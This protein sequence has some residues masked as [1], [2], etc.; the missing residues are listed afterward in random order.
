MSYQNCLRSLAN[1]VGRELSDKEIAAVYER[2]HKAALD[3]KSGRAEVGDIQ[4]GKKLANMGLAN[5]ALIQ[6][7]AERAARDLAFEAAANAK[8]AYLQVVRTGALLD[9]YKRLRG[10][11]LSP[12]KAV[13][14]LIFRNYGGVNVESLEQR[15][16]GVRDQLERRMI[17]SW[18]AMGDRFFGL[19]RDPEK[20]IDII[21]ELRGEDSGNA[22]AKA[23]ASKFHEVAEEARQWANQVGFHIG[24][25]NDWA[26]PQHHSQTKAANASAIVHGKASNDPEV[27]KKAWV[28]R[29]MERIDR[30][31]YV[32]DLGVQWSEADIRKSLEA[33]WESVST[34]G[35]S[36]IEPGKFV[37][38]SRINRHSQHRFI[39]YKDAQAVLDDWRE[40]GERGL[41]EIL[42]NHIQSMARDIAIAEF[43]GPRDRA[44]FNTLRDTAM[45]EAVELDRK[46]E[47]G[48]RGDFQSLEHKYDY[49][50][51]GPK[52]QS[53]RPGFSNFMDSIAHLNTAAK[54]GGFM[55]SSLFGDRPIYQAVAHL[56]NLPVVR[57][58]M[59][60]AKLFAS[61]RDRAALQR[62]G[63]MLD[64]VQVGLTRFWDDFG[65]SS[66]ASAA[67]SKVA[68]AVMRVTGMAAINDIPKA[69][70][71]AGL[72][73]AI[74]RELHKPFGK[75]AESDVRLLRNYGITE[76]DWKTW[77]LAPRD[78]NG[79]TP[80][81]IERITDDSLRQAGII[82]Q[83]A[84]AREAA[85][86][87]RNAIVKL[88]GAINTEADF[89][90]VTP[91]WRER[92]QFYS[93]AQRGSV[94]GEI[95]RAVLQFKSFPWAQLLRIRDLMA[96]A[97]SPASKASMAAYLIT[98]L[99]LAGA[100]TVQVKELISGRDP[101]NMRDKKFWGKAL[102]QS[103]ALGVYGDFVYS[104]G[105]NRI[106]YGPLEA[107]AGPTVGPVLDTGK[108]IAFLASAAADGRESF[109]GARVA[110]IAKSF[111]PGQNIW[112]AKAAIDNMIW[113]N[114]LDALSPGYITNVRHRRM[115]EFK[116]EYWWEPGGAP[117]RLP[118]FSEAAQ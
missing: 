30:S 118:N 7:A 36:K 75:L 25:L 87:R 69:A 88:L 94:K 42:F 32:D 21:K 97:D 5:D 31:R 74:G 8:A 44:T 72:F 15:V 50:I 114:V 82:S 73:Q 90:I 27:N 16:R 35:A 67:T 52:S 98:S 111:V 37:A 47:S 46:H 65:T 83:I 92:A 71:G 12:L 23:F 103:G 116:Q 39:H 84:S 107:M 59:T 115:K 105:Q 56:N 51:G 63:L 28:D 10:A 102:L 64:A 38:A 54:G 43:M 61:S 62:E 29:K 45:K 33:A 18:E 89:A 79:I 80:S 3:I 4:S 104:F 60:Q 70:F 77:Q 2:V 53:I 95:W 58:W 96:N 113:A 41:T 112:Y 106:G 68:N 40:F 93:E 20:Q 101:L 100:L 1:A 26:H 76:A 110:N 117:E 66:S 11:G 109:A 108:A 24:S 85:A 99:G 19:M 91:G 86:A 57:D 22:D 48:I 9:S 34:D 6:A 13:D 55:L 14:M 81:A 78:E 17:G 49:A